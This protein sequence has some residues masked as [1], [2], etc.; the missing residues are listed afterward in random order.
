MLPLEAINRIRVLSER[1]TG[2]KAIAK[3]TGDLEKYRSQ[4]PVS[5]SD[6]NAHFFRG[7]TPKSTRLFPRSDP[8]VVPCLQRTLSGCTAQDSE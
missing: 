5:L 7:A 1:G 3:S 8:R 2:S 4:V 6:T